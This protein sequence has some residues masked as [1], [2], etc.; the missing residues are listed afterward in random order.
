MAEAML[1]GDYIKAA[2]YAGDAASGLRRVS[3]IIDLLEQEQS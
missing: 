2:L 3:C 1:E